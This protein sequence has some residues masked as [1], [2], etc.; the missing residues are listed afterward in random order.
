M[1]ECDTSYV[2]RPSRHF[3]S[4]LTEQDISLAFT[5]ITTG[6]VII[7][8]SDGE[9]GIVS[10]SSQFDRCMGLYSS[11]ET[12][13]LATWQQL[14]CFRRHVLPQGSPIGYESIYLPRLTYH[15]GQLEAHDVVGMGDA[16]P[17]FVNTLFNCLAQASVSNNFKPV[18]C[19]PFISALVPEDRCHL[20]GVAMENERPRYV[21]VVA[22]TD[23]KGAW[24]S[25]LSNGGAIIDV[26]TGHPIITGLS[27]PHA[28]R[29][30]RDR[31]WVL[32]SGTGRFGYFDNLRSQ[33]VPIV[34]CPGF[35]RGLTFSKDYAIV[36]TSLPRSGTYERLPLNNLL[37]RHN[38][39]PACAVLV[40]DLKTGEIC[41]HLHIEGSIR[42]LYDVIVLPGQKGV[43][44]AGLNASFAIPDIVTVERDHEKL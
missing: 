22:L 15:T 7:A 39:Q 9:R 33:F 32:D 20:N 29:I 14:W 10:A 4:W 1:G 24:R 35:L 42:E 17:L 27:M 30:Y 5:S 11:N 44:I 37:A 12:L 2:L 41:H 26:E 43:M 13:C 31:L 38:T 34:F 40:I 6:Q 21:T 28:P 25:C 19:P 23:E 18:W 8:S 3:Y 36:T 16:P